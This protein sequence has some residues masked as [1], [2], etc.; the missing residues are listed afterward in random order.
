MFCN[1]CQ[2]HTLIARPPA[3]PAG[4]QNICTAAFGV[5]SHALPMLAQSVSARHTVAAAPFAAVRD[6]DE[7]EQRR[8]VESYWALPSPRNPT[9]VQTIEGGGHGLHRTLR[10]QREI[11]YS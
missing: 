5:L 9:H 4:R 11:R 1:I 6:G 8:R 7:S 3:R 2:L 10:R